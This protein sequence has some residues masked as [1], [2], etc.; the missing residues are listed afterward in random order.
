MSLRVIRQR[1]ERHIGNFHFA[2]KPISEYCER[3][4]SVERIGH[5]D[6]GLKLG[7]SVDKTW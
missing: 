4:A 7:E 2:E 1:L 3:I 5:L 6:L